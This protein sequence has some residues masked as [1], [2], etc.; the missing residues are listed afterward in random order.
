MQP[1]LNLSG[2]FLRR[3]RSNSLAENGTRWTA[4]DIVLINLDLR[5]RQIDFRCQAA[6]G[7]RALA[8]IWGFLNAGYCGWDWDF[9]AL[10]LKGVWLMRRDVVG[11]ERGDFVWSMRAVGWARCWFCEDGVR[12]WMGEWVCWSCCWMGNVW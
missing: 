4:N 3:H 9:R 11:G 10:G 7:E 6:Y 2:E 12:R 8:A 1:C 5:I